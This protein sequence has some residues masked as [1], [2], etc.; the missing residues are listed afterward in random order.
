MCV[1]WGWMT[2]RRARAL[3][4]FRRLRRLGRR[5]GPEEAPLDEAEIEDISPPH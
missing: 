2:M 5:G 1:W 4:M 3:C